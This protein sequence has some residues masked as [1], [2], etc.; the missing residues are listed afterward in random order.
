[1]PTDKDRFDQHFGYDFDIARQQSFDWLKEQELTL[2]A[3]Q[4]GRPGIGLDSLVV[5]PANA[6]FFAFGLALLQGILPFDQ[7][8][9]DFAPKAVIFTV[10]PFRHTHFRRQAGGGAQPSD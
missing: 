8:G 10:P 1:M 5:A 3:F 7:I 9:A 4:A 6:A 2:F